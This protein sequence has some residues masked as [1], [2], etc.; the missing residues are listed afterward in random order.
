[1]KSGNNLFTNEI[2]M[3]CVVLQPDI[4]SYKGLFVYT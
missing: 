3:A 4:R 2:A 1:M